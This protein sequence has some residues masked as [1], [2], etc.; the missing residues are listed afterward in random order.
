MRAKAMM[1]GLIQ[2]GSIQSRRL[3]CGPISWCLD[4]A[5]MGILWRWFGIQKSKRANWF[6]WT[7]RSLLILD[8][9]LLIPPS[10]RLDYNS[11]Q[12]SLWSPQPAEERVIGRDAIGCTKKIFFHFDRKRKRK[13]PYGFTSRVTF[14]RGPRSLL[15]TLWACS[16]LGMRS[17]QRIFFIFKG[18]L[19]R[20]R[21][22]KEVV[23]EI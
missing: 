2:V 10:L 9:W 13:M 3:T 17:V 7:C 20:K 19:S 12:D 11:S 4:N 5:L 15:R 14:Q 21:T 23:I 16:I 1:S 6:F 8:C 18:K 22:D